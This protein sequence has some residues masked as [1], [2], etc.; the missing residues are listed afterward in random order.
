M[1]DKHG[2]RLSPLS[3]ISLVFHRL[4]TLED[5]PTNHPFRKEH[6]L[7]HPPPWNYVPAVNLQGCN[8]PL[9]RT[10]YWEDPHP[11]VEVDFFGWLH[12]ALCLKTGR[13][14]QQG[15]QGGGGWF[16]QLSHE[17]NPCYFPLYWLIDRD[18]YNL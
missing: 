4:H 1:V 14:V 8:P 12:G 9:T 11:P 15:G 13:A 6:D 3:R 16:E 2:D 10:T 7:N 5:S 17:K 18:P